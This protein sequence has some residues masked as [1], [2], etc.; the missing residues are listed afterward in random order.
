MNKMT[1][2][3]FGKAI[4]GMGVMA[5]VPFNLF[6][7]IFKKQIN[8]IPKGVTTKTKLRDGERIRIIKV[9]YS[10]DPAKSPD[11]EEGRKWLA[12]ELKNYAG[13]LNDPIWRREM[14]VEYA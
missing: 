14:E 7:Q 8:D 3:S 10:A 1:R 11:T 13:G 12:N 5:L 9:H 4:L 2:R 6:R